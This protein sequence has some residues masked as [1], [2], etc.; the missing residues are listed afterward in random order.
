MLRLIEDQAQIGVWSV[1]L[2]DFS[3]V[4]SDGLLRIAGLPYP[5]SNGNAVLDLVHPADWSIREEIWTALSLGLS[6]HRELRIVRPDRTV[7]WVE[8][9]ADVVIGLDG[10]PVRTDGI[11]IDIT[12]RREAARSVDRMQARYQGLVQA[13]ASVVWIRSGDG[14]YWPCPS[15]CALTGQSDAEWR[16]GGWATA[17]HPEDRPRAMQAWATAFERRE[18]Y[19]ANYRLRCADG[20]YCWVNS[21]AVPLID[22]DQTGC[23]WIGLVLDMTKTV[24]AMTSP[25]Q[26][27]LDTLKGSLVR[28]ARAM[29][30]WSIPQLAAA[31]QV[32]ESSVKRF[33]ESGGSALRPRTCTAIRTALEAAGIL[34]IVPSPG[35]VGLLYRP[36]QPEQD[37]G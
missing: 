5:S 35:E 29:L 14:I 34:F 18:P 30:N 10:R 32:S 31:A 33:E 24:S 16:S 6:V 28:S 19:E 23:E 12:S 4:L 15:W 3:V 8:I 17:I 27:R 11:V 9:K 26:T 2:R 22:A 21:R 20:Q 1:D 7:R 13:I 37:A 36:T 25:S